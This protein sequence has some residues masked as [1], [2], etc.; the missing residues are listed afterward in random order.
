MADLA[1]LLI[2]LVAE[3]D[4]RVDERVDAHLAARAAGPYVIGAG[5]DEEIPAGHSRRS[6]MEACRA[7]AARGDVRVRR[8][9]RRWIADRA[10]FDG[11]DR[12]PIAP[13]NDTPWSPAWASAQ[14]GRR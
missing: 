7:L 14:G 1:A 8:A 2:S 5:R 13:A 12:E 10:V 3:I 4:R 6:A 9:G 11:A